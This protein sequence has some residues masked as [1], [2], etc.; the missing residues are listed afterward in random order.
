MNMLKT[1]ETAFLR[2]IYEKG[3][4]SQFL[5]SPDYAQN[6]DIYINNCFLGLIENLQGKFPICEMILGKAFFEN[7]AQKY[8]AQNPQKTGENNSFGDE[9]PQ[10]IGQIGNEFDIQYIGE[11]AQIEWQKFNA[12]IAAFEKTIDFEIIANSFA[13]DEHSKIKLRDCVSFLGTK[14]NA[15]DIYVAHLNDEILECTIIETPQN[16]M[17][18]VDEDFNPQFKTVTPFAKELIN[19]MNETGEITIALSNSLSKIEN[20]DAAQSEFIELCNLGIFTIN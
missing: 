11:I 8:I 20:Q 4:F 3:D 2:A 17:I 19:Q 14:Y 13:N 9:F 7:A 16:I 12:E 6:F 5:A 18:W 1:Y 15:F 10:F